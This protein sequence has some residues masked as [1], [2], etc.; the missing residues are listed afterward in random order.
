MRTPVVVASRI[1][2]EDSSASSSWTRKEE[3]KMKKAIV[4]KV[5][6]ANKRDKRN[7]KLVKRIDKQLSRIEKLITQ[8]HQV[9]QKLQ[10][11]RGIYKEEKKAA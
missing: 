11:I 5:A 8:L 4:T 6:G 2:D 1:N 7:R 10:T 9:T 3:A